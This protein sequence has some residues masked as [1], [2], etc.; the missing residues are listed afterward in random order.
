MADFNNTMGVTEGLDEL[1]NLKNNHGH[2]APE[3]GATLSGGDITHVPV[4]P[5]TETNV[6]AAINEVGGM[7]AEGRIHV[8]VRQTV[9]QGKK[10]YATDN[11]TFLIAVV[12][13]LKIQLLATEVPLRCTIADGLNDNGEINYVFSFTEDIAEAWTLPPNKSFLQLFIEYDPVTKAKTFGYTELETAYTKPGV[14]ALDQHWFDEGNLSIMQRW[15]G[16]AWEK[17]IR[18]M[19]GEAVTGAS[20]ITSVIAYAVKGQ[21]DSGWFPVAA[22]QNYTRNHNIGTKISD[23][24]YNQFYFSLDAAGVDS[25]FTHGIHVWPDNTELGHFAREDAAN[26]ARIYIKFGFGNRVQFYRSASRTTGYYRI[27]IKRSW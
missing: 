4:A 17:K 11:S 7:V 12:A 25:S 24:F 27:L 5:V 18:L 20:S 8:P 19:V 22:N 6:S 14:P 2:D 23:G 26:N 15:N 13:Q 10:D 16:S 3:E 21:Y 9:L 1:N